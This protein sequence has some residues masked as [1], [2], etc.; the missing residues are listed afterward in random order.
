MKRFIIV[1]VMFSFAFIGAQ[2]WLTDYFNLENP[3]EDLPERLPTELNRPLHISEEASQNGPL[4]EEDAVENRDTADYIGAELAD[5]KEEK[6]KTERSGWTP[7]GYEWNVFQED[8]NRSYFGVDK[9]ENKVVSIIKTDPTKVDGEQVFAGDDYEQLNEK[10]AFNNEVD[11][12]RGADNFTFELTAADLKS[13]PLVQLEDDVYAQFYFD[14]YEQ[15][16]EQIRFITGEPLLKK[17]P[18]AL[19]YRGTLP[20][21]D[22]LSGENGERWAESQAIQIAELTNVIREK[23]ELAPLEISERVAETAKR[24]SEEMEEE[25]YF[26][27]DSPNEG[28]L[29]DRLNR[30]GI[31]YQS[32]AENIAARYVDGLETTIGWLNSEGHRVNLLN[33]DFTH[34]GV[35]VY[36]RYYTQNFLL[37]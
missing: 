6:G 31:S 12:T 2:Y 20:E 11:V 19:S 22:E 15:T 30:D 14:T 9:E 18:Y 29:A 26:A 3:V 27:H 28:S 21:K 34:I 16:L 35:G 25:G 1:L 4:T 10:F 36:R 8:G 37:K 32:A 5:L 13:K 17:R 7:Y 23:R 33:E 24:H